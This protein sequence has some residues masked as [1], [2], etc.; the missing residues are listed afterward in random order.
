MK[1]QYRVRGD[2]DVGAR[3][4]SDDHGAGRQALAVDDDAL[5]GVPGFLEALSVFEDC[6]AVVSGDPQGRAGRVSRAERR[7]GGRYDGNQKAI[8]QSRQPCR[9]RRLVEVAHSVT[10]AQGSFEQ[11]KYE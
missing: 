5:T 7:A 4:H 1:S 9:I 3:D 11:T 6:S 2:A 10:P 8:W